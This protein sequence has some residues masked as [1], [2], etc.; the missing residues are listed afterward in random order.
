[1][2]RKVIIG[3]EINNILIKCKA[4]LY[5]LIWKDGYLEKGKDNFFSVLYRMRQCLLWLGVS[6]NPCAALPC[7]KI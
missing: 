2:K 7:W 5:R 3:E 4:S 1:M 6:S